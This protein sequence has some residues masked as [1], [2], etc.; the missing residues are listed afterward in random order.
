MRY[1]L[2]QTI[3]SPIGPLRLGATDRGICL[4]E[5]ADHPVLPGEFE[6]LRHAV[7]PLVPGDNEHLERLSDQLTR[8]FEGT[9]TE[10]NVTLD[11]VRG[12]PFQRVVWDRLLKI[13]YGETMSY[14]ALAEAIGRLGA[15]RAVGGANRANRIAIVVPCHRV[16][17]SDGKLRGYSG[18]LWRKQFLLDLEAATRRIE[19]VTRAVVQ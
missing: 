19:R 2:T 14:G 1:I 6:Q 17:Q 10:F 8:Y 12:T 16:V 5:F 11:I 7:G 15:Q 9:L 4:L 13:P 3:E 18:G